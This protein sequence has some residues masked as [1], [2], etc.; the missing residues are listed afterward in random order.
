MSALRL[1]G[2][3]V[4]KRCREPGDPGRLGRRIVVAP[5][6]PVMAAPGL[7][8][9]VAPGLPVVVGA[10]RPR[11]TTALPQRCGCLCT[12]AATMRLCALCYGVAVVMKP[13][14]V[15]RQPFRVRHRSTSGRPA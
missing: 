9:V 2:D 11:F 5:G 1:S 6:L 13:F 12:A 4:A 8:V 7:P 3:P 15:R 10:A 14:A